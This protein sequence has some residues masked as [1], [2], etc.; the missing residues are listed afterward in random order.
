VAVTFGDVQTGGGTTTFSM[1]VP[2]HADGDLMI[3]VLTGAAALTPTVPGG[4]NLEGSYTALEAF[5]YVYSR[6][7]SSE[8]ASYS[9]T[10]AST[11]N[12]AICFCYPGGT[13]D[14]LG[15][16]TNSGTGTSMAITGLTASAAGA[17][18]AIS[19]GRAS[20]SNN[21]T[22]PAGMVERCDFNSN[23]TAS[24][25]C[26]EV[27]DSLSQPAGATGTITSTFSGSSKKT[28][29]LLMIKAKPD[30]IRRNA[31]VN[32]AVMRAANY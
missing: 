27:A 15:T 25:E 19:A 30:P 28:G 23:A 9:W 17:L 16:F 5:M 14:V 22:P 29:V 31:I 20:S 12:S 4:W 8:P 21:W 11:G 13:L 10:V 26:I 24:A 18:I 1:T 32:Q 6:T 7:A 2:A 3:T